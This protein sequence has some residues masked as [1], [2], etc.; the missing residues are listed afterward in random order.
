MTTAFEHYEERSGIAY[1]ALNVDGHAAGPVWFEF[2]EPLP[3]LGHGSVPVSLPPVVKADADLEDPLVQVA[4]RIELR[5][6][7]GFERFVL[8]EKLLAV[9]LLDTGEQPGRRWLIAPS[10]ACGRRLSGRSSQADAWLPAEARTLSPSGEAAG[11][12]R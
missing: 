4:D 5:D 7:D 8:L 12:S 6:P 3:E 11:S 9:E 2:F 1:Q 10:G